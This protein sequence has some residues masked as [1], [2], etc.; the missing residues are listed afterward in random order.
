MPYCSLTQL[1][2]TFCTRTALTV[3]S[4]W[5]P[6]RNSLHLPKQYPPDHLSPTAGS[7]KN[8]KK[9]GPDFYFLASVQQGKK[10][11]KNHQKS[12]QTENMR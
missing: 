3:P 2:E 11:K 5:P 7:S 12:T 9:T 1:Q 10:N 8:D 6:T 4:S